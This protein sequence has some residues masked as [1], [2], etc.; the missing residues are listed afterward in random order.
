ML[1]T[2]FIF[3]GGGLLAYLLGAVPCGYLIARFNGV[4]IR[5]VGSGNI[6]A[7]NVFRSVGRGWGMLTFGCDA[8]KGFIPAWIFP[9]LALSLLDQHGYGP[10]LTIAYACLAI[11]GHNWPVYLGFKGGKG[12]ATS[13]GALMGIAP[14]IAGLGLLIW[15]VVFVATRYVSVASIVAAGAVGITAWFRCFQTEWLIS[16]VLSLLC[17]LVIWRH[18][19]NIQRLLQGS[20]NRFQFRRHNPS[21][22]APPGDLNARLGGDQ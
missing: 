19:A 3:S 10:V 4:D 2:F 22:G 5:T 1:I 16:S 17:A 21:A 15:I 7:T 11:I 20:E 12:V 14:A 13:L 9:R 18:K 6:G 8:L